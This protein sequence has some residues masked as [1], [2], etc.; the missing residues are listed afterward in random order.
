MLLRAY[1]AYNHK[2]VLHLSKFVLAPGGNRMRLPVR[3][4]IGNPGKLLTSWL[5]LS[6]LCL[7]SLPVFAQTMTAEFTANQTSGCAPL[8]VAF[9]DLTT[10]NP[11]F[12]NWDFG[13]G[14]LSN[15]Q[16]PGVTYSSPGQ[17]TV[18]LV[19]RNADG[20]TGIT[21][22]DYITVYP[23]PTAR[24]TANKT[25]GC[26][27]VN[28]QFTDQSTSSA[29][30]IV[31]WQWDFGDGGTSTAQSPSHV[32]NN[33]GFYN[34][35]LTVTSSTGC[36]STYTATRLIRIV[37]GVKA[38]FT[39]GQALSCQPPY[40]ITFANQ[41]S[42]PGNMTFLWDLGNGSNSTQ[43]N[44]GTTYTSNNTYN[45]TLTATSEFGCSNTIT[46]PITLSGPTTVIKAP[47][48]VC[49]N[50]TVSFVNDGSVAPQKTLWDFGNGVQ[51]T[52]INDNTV[53]STTGNHTVKVINTYS[54]CK[55][56]AIRQIYV[57]PAPVLDFTATNNAACKPPLT[58]TFQDASAVPNTK[59]DWDFGDGGTGT[60]SPVTHLYNGTGTY[61]VTGTFTN[62]NG[63]SAKVTKPSVVKIEAPTVKINNVRDGGC[64]PFTYRPTATATSVDGIASWLWEFGDGTTSTLQNPT[65][66]YNS[67][68]T[69][70]IKLTVTTSG[71]C[72]ATTTAAGGV[73]VGTPPNTNFSMS[74][75][76]AC[77][78]DPIQFTDLT[79]PSPRADE[80]EWDFGDGGTSTEQNPT[81]LY[82]DS[83]TFIVQ[84]TAFNNRCGNPSA[85]QTVH[86]KPPIA[87]FGH[88]ITCGSLN[89]VFSDSSKTDPS[90]GPVSYAWTF[91]SPVAGNPPV[92]TSTQQNPTF[93]FPG[94][95]VYPVT[96]TVTNGSC[97]HTYIDTVKLVK[98]LADFT[99]PAT[100]CRNANFTILSTNTNYIVRY[101]W[102]IDGGPWN[103]AGR[104]YTGNFSTFGPHS[105]GLVITDING[106]TDTVIKNNVVN[107]IGPVANFTATPGGCKNDIVT[108][109]DN[110]TSPNALTEWTFNFG[111]GQTKSFT[112]AP[113][114][115]TY[116]DTGSYNP[117]LTVQDAMGCVDTYK[118][119]DT[120]FIST[121]LAGFTSDYDT[122]CPTSNVQFTDESAGRGL[123][124]QWYFGNGGTSTLKDP[125]FSYGGNNAT[126]DVKL[127]ITDRGGCKDSVTR[128]GYIT[129]LKPVPA[130]DIVDTL[131]ICPPIETKFTFKGMYYEALEWNFGDGSS[132]SLLNPTHFYNSFGNYTA[133]LVLTGYGGC[134]DS[135][136][137][138]I[139]VLNPGNV[140]TL[141]Y[142]PL[143]ACNELTVNFSLS[144]IPNMKYTFHFG[145]GVM[146]TTMATSYTHFYKSPAFY[147]PYLMYIDNQGCLAN[148]GGPQVK[149]IG[150]EPFFGLDRKKFCDS[151][152][153]YFTNYTIGN[154][155]VVTRTWDFGD[156]SPT[157]S[158]TDPAHNYQQPGLYLV[159]QS[160]TTQQGCAKTITDTIRVYRTPDPYIV[161]DSIG[162]LNETLNLQGMLAVPDT[163]ITWK[164]TPS[165][166]N[167][168]NISL[169]FKNSGTYPISLQA[170]NLL[171]CADTANTSVFVPEIPQITVKEQPVIP[172]STG[173]NLPVT[174]GPEVISY[175]WTPAKNLSCT[176]CP[177]PYANPKLTTTY[178]VTVADQ[179]G[180]LNNA[181]VTVTTVCNGLNYFLPNT[182]S[183]NGDGVNDIFAPRGVGIT[184]VNS[185]RIFN[186]WGEMVYERMNFVANDRTPGGGWDGNYKGKPA[187]ADVYIYIIEFVCENAAIVPVKG[188][189]A[190]V[191]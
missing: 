105:V 147:S 161:A 133:W 51:S 44:P 95:N 155:P 158:V 34:V 186:R 149:V 122:I 16:N 124:Y 110:S 8:H 140:T 108:F 114:T 180:C 73:K 130:F 99:I 88:T 170:T 66:T 94:F 77:A 64:V 172:V 1:T 107:V 104:G 136:S 150:A 52:N 171:G 9:R 48:T 46:Q 190:L 123:S 127:V 177:T 74:P 90:Y 112:S 118:L 49:Q 4:R 36:K 175:N 17:Y 184:R 58:V 38:A 98:E 61:N 18:R 92:G 139:H 145:D 83:G 157:T 15:V 57:Q 185:M 144:T 181:D 12:W 84:L 183:P 126:Y 146:D 47:D 179:Y 63:C 78:S 32:Y 81:H 125:I 69:Y 2:T 153:V 6:F 137:A 65:H 82:L 30:N 87:K 121:P 35:S 191:R 101:Q 59:W 76:D 163:G 19:V 128:N 71:G 60:G 106:C 115:H 21:K 24:F 72:T 40:N 45:V 25:L 70:D 75:I 56:S 143:D 154:D 117:Q 166:S 131:T 89:I 174:Y 129:T 132:S 189:V 119:T 156:G 138:N 182:F 28:I 165:N 31:S 176:D 39:N 168:P 135:V 29:G 93:P 103:V 53:Y 13:N 159:S 148:V 164:W 169:N 152:I 7:I 187:S 142:S 33:T 100:V 23:S 20:T 80:W 96:L 102:S 188:N 167:Q 116:A 27:P 26:V 50:Q 141:N 55:D 97:T 5:C 42:G 22:T 11:K 85:T 178:T 79:T 173:V 54:T 160:V 109:T 37:A 91:G 162:C 43:A 68:G 151:G 67:T 62:A 111:D 134:K 14:T 86:I 120:V 3:F 113:F 10:G 41:S